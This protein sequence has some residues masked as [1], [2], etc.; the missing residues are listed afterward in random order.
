MTRDYNPLDREQQA[1]AKAEQEKRYRLE[2]E[3]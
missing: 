2:A 1:A 3:Q